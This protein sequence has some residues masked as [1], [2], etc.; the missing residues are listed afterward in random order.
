MKTSICVPTVATAPRLRLF[1]AFF[2]LLFS[3]VFVSAQG[4]GSTASSMSGQANRVADGADLSVMKRLSGHIPSWAT[5][6]NDAGEAA[7]GETSAD[8][9]RQITFV[10]NRSPEKEAAFTQLLAEQQNPASSNYHKWLSPEEIGTL[11]GP[12][13]HDISA[14]TGWLTTQGLTVVEV[15]PTNIFVTVKGPSETVATALRTSFRTF[16]V[17]NESRRSVTVEPSVPAALASLVSSVH[18]LSDIRVYHGHHHAADARPNLTLGDGTKHVITPANFAAIYDVN[19]VYHAGF[20]G[21]GQNV[22]VVSDS[23]IN[24][25]DISDF[26]NRMGLPLNLPTTINAEQIINPNLPLVFSAEEQ[27]ADLDVERVIGTAPGAHVDLI[28]GRSTGWN[29][30]IWDA[31]KYAIYN[32]R[33]PILSISYSEG[34][35]GSSYIFSTFVDD[36]MD[37]AAEGISV[38]VSSG[39]GGADTCFA[40]Q[41]TINPICASPYVTC[42]GG[43]EL[44]E[45]NTPGAYWSD[46]P[47][48]LATALKY[49]PEVAWND[50]GSDSIG[51]G[52]AAPDYIYNGGTPSWQQNVF[53]VP[54]D[55]LRYIPDISFAASVV[56]D[57]YYFALPQ[58]EMVAP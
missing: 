18:G 30:G 4:A 49:I 29:D 17:N 37:A 10:L 43:T 34:C 11:Y 44:N 21:T 28:V 6:A 55:G 14:L 52:G 15:S 31:I 47:N 12:T 50:N 51:G 39:D 25:T 20:D 23:L 36:F 53:G 33:D 2:C 40:G 5:A 3:T 54:K 57:G 19:P 46:D 24:E 42:V 8:T 45:G 22:A 32:Q 41:K 35:D 16:K 26:E 58:P 7:A 38:F 48:N 56:H 27:E 13:P 9:T 1:C